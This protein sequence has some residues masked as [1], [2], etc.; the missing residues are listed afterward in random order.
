MSLKHVRDIPAGSLVHR[1]YL[2]DSNRDNESIITLH[3][4]LDR[5]KV[6]FGEDLI[7]LPKSTLKD[8]T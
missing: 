4:Q 1:A 6:S 3:K 7:K 2:M 8:R 5:M